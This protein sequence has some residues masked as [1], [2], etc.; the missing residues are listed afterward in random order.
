MPDRGVQ[1]RQATVLLPTYEP[2]PPD[3]YPMFLEKRVYQGSSGKVYPLPFFNRIAAEKTEKEW[4]TVHLENDFIELMILPEIGGRIHIGR[5]KINGYDF[6]YRQNVIKPALVGLAGPWISGGVEFNWPQHHRPATYMPVDVEVE[7]HSDG[8][9]TVWLSDH[10]PM[11]R[12]KGMHGVCLHPDK[13]LVELK[14]RVYNRT[15]FVQTFLWWANVAAKVHEGYQSFFPPDVTHVADHARRAISTY[16]LCDRTYYGVDY[17][18]RAQHGVPRSEVPAAFVPAHCSKEE[19]SDEIPPYPPNDLSWYANI[20]VPTSYMCLG[21]EKDFF[22]GYDHMAKAGLVHVANHHISPGKKQWTWGNQEFGYA[23]DRN[24]TDGDGPYIELMAGVFTDNQPDFSFLNP[25]ETRT[26]SQFWY[27]IRMIGPVVEATSKAAL[28]FRI[29]KQIATIGI[30][31]TEVFHHS[32]LQLL[33]SGRVID[34]WQGDLTPQQPMIRTVPLPKRAKVDGLRVELA[35]QTGLA[36]LSY[37]PTKASKKMLPAAATEPLPPCDVPSAD[38]LY[39]IGVHLEQYRHATRCPATYWNEALRRD[40]GDARCNN[41]LGLWYLKRGEFDHATEFFQR[42]IAR[43]TERNANPRDGEPYYNLG[44]ALR[45]RGKDDEAYAAFYKAIW[46]QAWQ[47]A[48]YHALAEIDCCRQDWEAALAHLESALRVNT[49]NL[50]A[51]DLRA[52]VLRKRGRGEE[53]ERQLRSTL[54]LDPLDWWARYLLGQEITCDSQTRLDLALDFAR[55]GLF[56]EAITL[57]E[58][59]EKAP[60]AGA[61]PLIAYYLGW[62]YERTG[63][64]TEALRWFERAARMEPDYCFPARLEEIRI[65]ETAIPLNPRDAH[66]HYYYLGNLFYDK[67]RYDEAIGHWEQSTKIDPG[68]SIVWRNLGIAYHNVS[69]SST[70]ARAAYENAFRAN[71][72]ESRL[73]YERDQLWKRLRISPRRRLAEL[74]KYP[75]LV[76]ERDD[77]SVELCALLNQTGQSAVALKI[78]STRKFQ[79]WEGGE[80]LALGQYVRTHLCLARVAMRKDDFASARSYLE[81]ALACPTNLGEARHLLA[82]QSDVYYLLGEVNAALGDTKAARKHWERAAYFKGDFQQMSMRRFSEMTYFSALSLR[83]M[84]KETA[85]EKLFQQLLN[86]GRELEKARATIDYFA[87]S[88]PTM[89]LFDEDIQLRQE[90]QAL[91]IQAQASLGL[92]KRKRSRLLLEKVLQREPSHGL[93]ADLLAEI[94]SPSRKPHQ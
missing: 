4:K 88:L 31:V 69:H 57:M 8:S 85:A 3:K 22:G 7:E 51:R 38:E 73:L 65:L 86:Y 29:E 67:K 70:R 62:L 32:T 60:D 30:C 93:A 39:L 53:A 91:F 80:G 9:K 52:L 37:A 35:D 49:D 41:A 72:N 92:G 26:W 77:L 63:D 33:L 59:A 44:L 40:P 68:F 12:M 5:D 24:L 45:Y 16:P 17:A 11:C 42:S 64:R 61:G 47:P 78:V 48:A 81:A 54:E 34:S 20:P 14:V 28:S 75:E 83:R 76:K 27:P 36:V 15:P 46:N 56:L 79:P 55:A 2:L 21:S 82:N 50:R 58:G 43:V 74:Q 84:G 89:L 10:D 13:A 19:R 1:V 18:G 90:T 6:F 25:G 87:T 23:W 94:P 66:A 71:P